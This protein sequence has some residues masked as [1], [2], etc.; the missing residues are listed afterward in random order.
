MPA[1]ASAFGSYNFFQR[2]IEPPLD[3]GIKQILLRIKR[4]VVWYVAV[5]IERRDLRGCTRFESRLWNWSGCK[6]KI[7]IDNNDTC[8]T[9]QNANLLTQAM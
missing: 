9:R 5:L 1:H 4:R 7:R 2:H 6:I 8:Y 3:I